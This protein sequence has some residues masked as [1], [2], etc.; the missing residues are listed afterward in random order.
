MASSEFAIAEAIGTAIKTALGVDYALRYG[1]PDFSGVGIANDKAV[2]A[3]VQQETSSVQTNR[4]ETVKPRL[5]I[6]VV[7][8]FDSDPTTAATH[9]STLDLMTDIR[10]A[11]VNRIEAHHSGA[12]PIPGL[13]EALIYKGQTSTPA[14][15]SGPGGQESV[16]ADFDFQFIRQVGA[17]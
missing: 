1:I 3:R 2:Y 5:S 16:T 17:R 8:P 14:V 13:S 12:T 15:L 7:R 10:V 9:Q 4:T 11:I 6:Y